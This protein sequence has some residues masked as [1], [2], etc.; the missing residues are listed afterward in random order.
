M[1]K[2]KQRQKKKRQRHASIIDGKD[3]EEDGKEKEIM[4]EIGKGI[5]G[6]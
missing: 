5:H 2:E 4:D 1:N 3:D 6:D